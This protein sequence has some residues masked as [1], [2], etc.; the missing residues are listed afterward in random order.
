MPSILNF[1]LTKSTT[2]KIMSFTSTR[3]LPGFMGLFLL[4]ILSLLVPQEAKADC[5]WLD[6][7][8]KSGPGDCLFGRCPEESSGDSCLAVF[9]PAK[10]GTFFI[11]NN[12]ES[13][14]NFKL[15][16]K[17]FSLAAPSDG[18]ANDDI[19]EYTFKIRGS[20]SSSCDNV[21]S[22]KAPIIS[23]DSSSAP[24]YQEKR[25]GV[26]DGAQYM[27]I[28]TENGIDMQKIPTME[29]ITPQ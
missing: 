19:G 7:T 17:P 10:S 2:M 16:S 8:C 20:S 4:P 26:S 9:T 11:S 14:I 18:T 29:G 27:F 6:P 12:T 28:T 3:I 5:G 1:K 24:G 13:S 25:Y 22:Y 21:T 15:G 23:F